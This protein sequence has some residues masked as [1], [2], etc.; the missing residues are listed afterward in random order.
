MQSFA[1]IFA[2][3][4]F[5]ALFLAIAQES[6]GQ[7]SLV[8]DG[9]LDFV[10]EACTQ[11]LNEIV[12]A[13]AIKNLCFTLLPSEE[14]IASIPNESEIGSCADVEDG[15]CPITSRCPQCKNEADEFFKC[16]IVNKN[17]AGAISANVTD[18][19]AGCTLD[20]ISAETSDTT[21]APAPS[22]TEAPA[23]E[24]S[25]PTDIPYGTEST[26]APTESAAAKMM[27]SSGSII[28]S[29]TLFLLAWSSMIP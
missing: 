5:L 22:P 19:I 6:R 2:S 26:D 20:C 14:E 17:V 25:A 8:P 1:S 18:L 27:S 21:A 9:L 13:C 15:L 7:V 23:P 16:I 3:P 11:A 29:A 12:L 10:P 4:L 24:S 28:G